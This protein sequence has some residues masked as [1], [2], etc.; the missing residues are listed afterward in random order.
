MST[1]TCSWSGS[2]GTR[3]KP[4]GTRTVSSASWRAR[5]AKIKLR[6]LVNANQPADVLAQEAVRVETFE[7]AAERIVNAS[8]IRT[9]KPRLDRLRRHVFPVIGS[10]PVTESVAG[11]VREILETLASAGASKE[12]C[13]W[14]MPAPTCKRP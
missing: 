6:R 7:A 14:P 9:K 2:S 3:P 8:A 13:A 12:T 4:L 1:A 5:V 10:K 11:D